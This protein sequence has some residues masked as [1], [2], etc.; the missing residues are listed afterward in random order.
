M[1]EKDH[2]AKADKKTKDEKRRLEDELEEGLE[3]SFPASDPVSV[4]QPHP[5]EHAPRIKPKD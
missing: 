1:I 4:T 5:S 3:D 2:D